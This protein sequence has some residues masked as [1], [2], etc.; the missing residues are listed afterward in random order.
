MNALSTTRL[1]LTAALVLTLAAS[2]CAESDAAMGAP[3]APN[4]GP[5][6]SVGISQAGAQDFGLF[7][8]I[9]DD[10]AIPAPNTLDAL[11]FFAEHKL[12]YP[13]AQCGQD[14]C[15]HGLV[16]VMGNLI[17]GANCTLLQVG[18]NS[19]IDLANYERP[20]LN[21]VLAVDLTF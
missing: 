17:T 4:V 21:L 1:V 14:L 3:P 16:G 7:R 20:P 18:M 15:V 10:G 9:L 13:Q 5:P 8:Q 6:G 19:P 2:G 11:G 12:D